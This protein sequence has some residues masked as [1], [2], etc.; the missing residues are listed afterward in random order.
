[1][2]RLAVLAKLM[3][4][5]V[6]SATENLASDVKMT[7]KYAG[8]GVR[9]C[10]VAVHGDSISDT[11]KPDDI[12]SSN[13]ELLEANS[14]P[15]GQLIPRQD[16]STRSQGIMFS[17]TLRRLVQSARGPMGRLTV[18]N[19]PYRTKKVWP[20]DFKDLTP[21]Q[22]LRFEKKYKR[23]LYLAH[24]SPTW[25]KGTRMVRFVLVTGSQASRLCVEGKAFADDFGLTS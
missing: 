15:A 23:R 9:G 25:D 3:P 13:R 11:T 2:S 8:C 14:Q 4:S 20:P 10:H 19:N 12:L 22:Q 7:H 5:L 1:M 16:H 21:Q 6:N 17:T 18:E 24:Y